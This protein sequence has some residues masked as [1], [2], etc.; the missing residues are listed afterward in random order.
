[1]W[2]V[3]LILD[4][5]GQI[6]KLCPRPQGKMSSWAHPTAFDYNDGTISKPP[7]KFSII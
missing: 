2:L 1:M 3:T 5:A 4:S 7:M 6:K